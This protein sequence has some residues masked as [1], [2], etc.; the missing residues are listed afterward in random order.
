MHHR[1]RRAEVDRAVARAALV[2]R[3][4]GLR[5]RGAHAE[6]ALGGA[7]VAVGHARSAARSARW[8][9]AIR[10]RVIAKVGGA[11]VE[12]DAGMPAHRIDAPGQHVGPPVAVE[13]PEQRGIVVQADEHERVDAVAH[14]L[15]GDAHLGVEVVVVLGQHQRISLASSTACSAL[16]VRA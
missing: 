15:L 14:E 7:V 5:E 1:P 12:A 6:A 16:V 3:E 9:S 2:E 10:W 11:V 8:P 13:Q 4:A